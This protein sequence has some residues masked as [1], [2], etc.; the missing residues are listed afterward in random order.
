MT[1]MI[2]SPEPMP[3]ETDA[4]L[5]RVEELERKFDELRR[6]ADQEAGVIEARVLE[7]LGKPNAHPVDSQRVEELERT[8]QSLRD[9]AAQHAQETAVLE[10]RFLEKLKAREA[11]EAADLENK[12][13]QRLAAR[14]PAAVPVA[15]IPIAKPAGTRWY[16]RMNPFKPRAIAP[17]PVSSGWLVFD[18][19][20]EARFLGSMILDSRFS[21]AWSSR[22]VLIGCLSAFFLIEFFTYPISFVPLIGGITVFLVDKLLALL[23]SFFIFKVL[24]RE[25]ARYK[26]FLATLEL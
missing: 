7:R 5:R 21:T 15:E 13:M 25:T 12:L 22:L 16:D 26:A 10:S 20:N 4:L 24:A 17:P 6:A 19:L 18:L 1:T 23:I 11:Q 3:P 14:V 2:D 8:I 9:Q